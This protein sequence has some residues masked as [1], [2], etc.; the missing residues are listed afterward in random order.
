MR[1]HRHYSGKRSM[2]LLLARDRTFSIE[3]ASA[4]F[5]G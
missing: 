5:D 2:R 1:K 3:E 4:F